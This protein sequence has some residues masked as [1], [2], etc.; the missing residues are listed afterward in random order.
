MKKTFLISISSLISWKV[1]PVEIIVTDKKLISGAISLWFGC[2]YRT[3]S[4]FSAQRSV[5]IS[6]LPLSIDLLHMLDMLNSNEIGVINRIKI[7]V[8]SLFGM[9]F[10]RLILGCLLW[11]FVTG[12]LFWDMWR[13]CQFIFTNF[14][15]RLCLFLWIFPVTVWVWTIISTSS[16]GLS[17]TVV[18]TAAFL[19]FSSLWSFD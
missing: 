15:I 9:T 4:W 7:Q 11:L 6:I 12:T 19:C 14:I 13:A 18:F 2:E 16:S 10:N 1:L 17:E 8:F 5:K 3:L